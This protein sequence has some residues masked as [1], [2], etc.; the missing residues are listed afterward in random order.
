MQN[1]VL[2]NFE[3]SKD[4]LGKHI[5]KIF[6]FYRDFFESVNNI[7]GIYV[8]DSSAI[9][10]LLNKD[11]FETSKWPVKVDT[12]DGPGRGKTWPAF[13]DT[14]NEERHALLPWRGRPKV[15]VCTGVNGDKVIE[16]LLS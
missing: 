16:L 3:N 8:H 11:L 13:G 10:Y 14:D 12:T 5:F 15:N 9:A 2:E 7:N 6:G 1:N 4:P